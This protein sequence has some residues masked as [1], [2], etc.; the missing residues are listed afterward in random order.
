MA[1]QLRAYARVRQILKQL[2]SPANGFSCATA[3][4]SG[5]S[6]GVP[7]CHSQVCGTHEGKDVLQYTLTN[8]QGI[9]ATI[10][11]LGATLTHLVV[12]DRQGNFEDVVTGYSSLQPYLDGTPFFGCV[13]GRY[14]NRLAKGRFTLQ[15]KTYDLVKNNGP[16][17][18]H[19]GDKG[20]D[21]K[22][23]S[24]TA[25][26]S[27][28]AGP[29]VVFSYVS[30]D[31]EEGYPGNLRVKVRYTLSEQAGGLSIDYWA[32]TDK[33]TPVNLTNHAYF[34]LA[35]PRS[36]SV[37]DHQLQIFAS[38]YTPVDET[39][40]PLGYLAPVKDTPFDFLTSSAIGSRIAEVIA[41]PALGYD[42]NFVL[43]K[44]D[45]TGKQ[46]EL[47]A[48]VEH[49]ESGR[50][51]EVYTTEAGLQLYTG[52]YLGEEGAP[53]GKGGVPYAQRSALCLECQNFP[54]SPNQPQ[55]HT[56]FGAPSPFLKPGEEYTQR[57]IYSFS[58]RK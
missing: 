47:A 21:K 19:G 8:K 41:T 1:Q 10:I 34:N 42:H 6:S 11:S 5:T 38:R 25:D 2:P 18:L 54:D 43:D 32:V 16:N 44:T 37:L 17:H 24:S 55:F 48:R 3:R 9:T 36:H 39:A 12:P 22:V 13:V 33:E 53:N 28:K 7:G 26:F 52:N 4:P 57:T 45:L 50:I 49:K 51:M 56:K 15:G 29:S 31:G 35:G 30:V 27:H 23:W 20:F 46:P 40:I 58:T 14:A